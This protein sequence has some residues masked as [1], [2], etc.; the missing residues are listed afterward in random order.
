VTTLGYICE[1]LNQD[2][3]GNL[4][5][6]EIEQMLSGICIGLKEHTELSVTAINALFNALQFLK[7]S[8]ENEKICDYVFELL[9]S[10]LQQAFLKK[11]EETLMMA[12]NCL[13][14]I[15]K[16][17]YNKMQR[18]YQITFK[19]VME[20]YMS[21]MDSVILAANEYFIKVTK[22]ELLMKTCYLKEFWQDITKIAIEQLYISNA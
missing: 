18:Y 8:L 15:T 17:V 21:K 7:P 9:L 20:C 5:N 13:R 16:M 10:M 1:Y 11:D 12:I 22:G 3:I 2:K 4:G 6:E 19:K 14:E